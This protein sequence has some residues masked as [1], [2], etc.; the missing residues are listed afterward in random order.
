MPQ[1]P[2]PGHILLLDDDRALREMAAAYLRQLGHEVDDVGTLEQALSRVRSR[3]YEVVLS[4]LVLDR[5]TGLDLLTKIREEEIPCEVII[6][7]GRGGVEAA[8]EAIRL[9]AYDFITK[10]LSMTRLE[11]DVGKALEKR[12]LERDLAR[13]AQPGEGGFGRLQGESPAMLSLFCSLEKAARCDSNVLLL[14]E[15]GTGK[16][17]AAREIHL[18]SAR[19]DGPFVPVHCGALPP[20]LLES[21]L[22][23]HRR[24]AFTGADGHRK[25]LFLTAQ[26]G[27]L[28]LDEIAT[29]PARVQVGLLRVLQERRIRP[30]GGDEDIEINVRIIAA[31]N[32]DLE[33]EIQEGRFRQDLYYRLA[34]IV[35]EMPP[36][37]R[38]REDIPRLASQIL[39][40]LARRGGRRVALSPRAVERLSRH[41]WLGNVRELEHFLESVSVI[42]EGNLVREKDLPFP[43]GE[44]GEEAVRTL[45]EVEREHISKVLTLCAGN[46]KRASRL[47]GIPRAT[48]YRKIE[49]YG[50]E[51]ISRPGAPAPA[52]QIPLPSL[53]KP[54]SRT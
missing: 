2:A 36:L 51:S 27:T 11:L 1:P 33:R 49:R 12:R 3:P 7:T 22:F 19:A 20:E 34:T 8:V 46:K 29:A 24:G 26:R 48:L 38:R 21:E 6:M 17:V 30:V 42:A 5:G 50:L 37:R 52:A 16:E 41:D 39:E 32:A 15:S 54:A 44:E 45:E 13:W 18:H 35:L 14:G 9:G 43:K 40:S 53:Q 28:F 47:L 31:T 10:P 4:D 25:G 23:G